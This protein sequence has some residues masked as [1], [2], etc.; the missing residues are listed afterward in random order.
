VPNGPAVTSTI[1][2][3]LAILA[4]ILLLVG[5]MTPVGSAIV[6]LTF[7]IRG[8]TPLLAAASKTVVEPL[9]FSHFGLNVPGLNLA[10]MALTLVLLGPGAFSVDAR[11][12]GRRIIPIPDGKRPAR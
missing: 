7:L 3:S 4:G 12:F 2:G 1:I 11:L 5:L 9:W 6:T 8:M 10:V